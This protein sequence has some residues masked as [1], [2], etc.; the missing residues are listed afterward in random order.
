VF[1]LLFGWATVAIAQVQTPAE[2]A[3]QLAARISSQLQRRPTASLEIR[4]L[5]SMPAP[6]L[7]HFRTVLDQELRKAG[8]PMTATQPETRV[9][10]TVSENAR[11]LLLVTELL[12]GDNRR[13]IMQ[14]WI[15]PP[16]TETKPRL[17]IVRKPIWEQSEPVL[18]L[19]LLDS[20]SEML[21]LSPTAVTAFRMIDG[22]WVTSGVA[23]LSPARPPARDPRGRL[24]ITTGGLRVY[25]PGTTCGGGLQPTLRFTCTGGNET[26]PVNTRDSSIIAHWVTDRNILKSEGFQNAFYAAADGWFS[27]ADHRII[28]RAGNVLIVPE[29]WGSDFANVESA[30]GATPAILVSGPGDNPNRDQVVAYEIAS[31]HAAP[32]SDPM[33]VQGQVT[34]LWPAEIGGQATLVVRNSKTGNYEVLRLGVACAE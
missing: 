15:A 10:V 33:T 12:S 32:T 23:V 22:K 1:A 24:E 31:G 28:D 13:V 8:L 20:G 3:A 2:A 29:A 5:S 25:L 4:N 7:S 6:D 27:T 19:L 16:A 21:V 30:C 11:G 9:R 18:D 34:A 14:P 26:W 17:K